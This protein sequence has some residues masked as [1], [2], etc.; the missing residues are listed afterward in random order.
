MKINL[1]I[2]MKKKMELLVA[3]FMDKMLE[4]DLKKN[5]Y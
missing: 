2:I 1:M 3:Y 5:I 4:T